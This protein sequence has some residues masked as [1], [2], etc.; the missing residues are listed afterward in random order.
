MPVV[1]F[2]AE[3]PGTGGIIDGTFPTRFAG[4][5]APRPFPPDQTLLTK[6]GRRLDTVRCAVDICRECGL[7]L[8]EC[9]G[10]FFELPWPLGLRRP[11]WAA[12]APP[13][14]EHDRWVQR[15]KVTSRSVADLDIYLAL[16]KPSDR[17]F[18]AAIDKYKSR[19]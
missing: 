9:E 12:T 14:I 17:G 19:D 13:E 10:S 16:R 18:F 7:K 2:L 8:I 4:R 15:I 1:F 3:D 5:N 6:V 11:K